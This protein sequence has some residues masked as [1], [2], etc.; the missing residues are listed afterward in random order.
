[1]RITDEDRV[2]EISIAPH[3]G[4]PGKCVLTGITDR[5]F[6][7][8]CRWPMSFRFAWEFRA[9]IDRHG[10]RVIPTEWAPCDH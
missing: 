1:M 6:H 8:R 3:D 9:D 10:G 4:I 7:V 2:T 5:G